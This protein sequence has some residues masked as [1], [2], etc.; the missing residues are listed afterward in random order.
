M[1]ILMA[2]L[3]AVGGLSVFLVGSG[4][5]F[6]IAPENQQQLQQ[7]PRLPSSSIT[8]EIRVTARVLPQRH[9][10]IDA[11]GAIIK[12][13]SNTVEDVKPEVFTNIDTPANKRNLTPE[14]YRQYRSRIPAG[15]TKSG[16]LYDSY[17]SISERIS[18]VRLTGNL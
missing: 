9:I 5:A 18:T 10:T 11:T 7:L 3:G 8:Q 16:V 12:I 6:A 17:S 15:T 4:Q 14:I 1:Q 2:I 13:T